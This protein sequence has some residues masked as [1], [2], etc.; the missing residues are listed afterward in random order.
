MRKNIIISIIVIIILSSIVYFAVSA[1]IS[2]PKESSS[3]AS[4]EHESNNPTNNDTPPSAYETKTD[5]QASVTVEVSPKIIGVNEEK[6]IF[7]VSFNTHSV[8]L[9]FNFA[10]IMILKDNLGNTY[11]V[12]EWTGNN[13]GHHIDGNIIFPKINE[14]TKS[15]ELQILG[16][17]GVIRSFKWDLK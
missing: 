13:E 8:D 10:K 17:G 3:M 14:R 7:A 2:N 4:S 5:N 11:K 15:I 1:F 6:N 9:N 12:L 16:V